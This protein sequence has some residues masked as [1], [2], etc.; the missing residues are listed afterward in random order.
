[1]TRAESL[2]NIFSKKQRLTD[3]FIL[4]KQLKITQSVSIVFVK[5]EFVN[6]GVMAL[7]W[8]IKLNKFVSKFNSYVFRVYTLVLQYL[9]INLPLFYLIVSISNTNFT[10]KLDFNCIFFHKTIK[11][12]RI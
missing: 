11:K 5:F 7:R 9:V 2:L 1:M 6:V 3:Q 12:V 10:T 8:Q 4:I